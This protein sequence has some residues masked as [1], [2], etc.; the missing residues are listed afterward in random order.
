MAKCRE[1]ADC[2]EEC[3]T[4]VAERTHGRYRRRATGLEFVVVDAAHC[5]CDG[6][7]SGPTVVWR[8]DGI[9]ESGNRQIDH[10]GMHCGD[11]VITKAHAR[12][13]TAFE[14]L[15]HDVELGGKVE[16]ELLAFGCL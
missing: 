3:G 1:N 11:V 14:I 10:A 8:C 5:F 4:D 16:D 12:K 13:R 7:V 2:A 15:G 9:A 6:G